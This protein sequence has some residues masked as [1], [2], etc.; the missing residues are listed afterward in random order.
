MPVQVLRRSFDTTFFLD[1]DGRPVDLASATMRPD[2]SLWPMALIL[3]DAT[4]FADDIDDACVA[5]DPA[6]ADMDSGERHAFIV[7][8]IMAGRLAVS[9]ETAE[10]LDCR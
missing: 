4:V 1:D 8:H 5:A 9:P 2:G 7:R 10:T 3:P 6:Y